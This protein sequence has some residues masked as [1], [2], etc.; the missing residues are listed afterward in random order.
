MDYAKKN[1]IVKTWDRCRSIPRSRGKSLATLSLSLPPIDIGS[2][3]GACKKEE[4][5][6]KSKCQVAPAGC[7]CVYVG[8]ERQRFV[9]K[10]EYANH[11]L[12]KMLLEDAEMEYGYCSEGPILLPCDVDLFY[13]VLA[14]MDHSKKIDE[15]EEEKKY[16]RS[17]SCGFAYGSCTPFSPTRRPTK[18]DMAK[19]LGSYSLLTP[20][21]SLG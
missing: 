3:R 19:G 1:I 10:T 16:G 13:K 17:T 14:E 5:K 6:R 15:E 12:F 9:I 7:F 8:P 21:R 18:R 2:R 20:S 4:D 11:P